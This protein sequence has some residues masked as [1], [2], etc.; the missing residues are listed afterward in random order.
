MMTCAVL[1]ELLLSQSEQQRI[2]GFVINRFRGDIA[3]L[4]HGLDWLEQRTGKPVFGVLPFLHDLY[5]ESEDSVVVAQPETEADVF[6]I[7]VPRVPRMSNHTDFD[8]LRLNAG[9]DIQFCK[10]PELA[11]A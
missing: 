3:I 1:S 6:R 4:Q 9:L 5:L 2:I 7:V 11:C 10:D 8:V